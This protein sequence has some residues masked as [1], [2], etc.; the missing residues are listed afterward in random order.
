M[1]YTNA[2]KEKQTI[3][4]DTPSMEEILLSIRNVIAGIAENRHEIPKTTA[5][6]FPDALHQPAP[7]TADEEVLEL[8]DVV[9][10]NGN[11]L[12]TQTLQNS[13]PESSMAPPSAPE[14]SLLNRDTVNKTANSLQGLVNKLR[15]NTEIPATN[16]R[17]TVEDLVTETL[18]PYLTSW[19]NQNLPTIVEK[20]VERE[21][22]KIV[23]KY[24]SQEN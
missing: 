6:V 15:K 21:V 17:T 11:L 5:S 1:G 7:I 16:S 22:K 8:T 10:S 18:K 14:D 20:I 13:T 24:A 9:D 19:I 23:E 3:S 2:L 12:S 4:E